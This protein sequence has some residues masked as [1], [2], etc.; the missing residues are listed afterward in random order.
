[1]DDMV[2]LTMSTAEDIAKVGQLLLNRGSYGDLEFFSPGTFEQLL[3]LSLRELY[4]IDTDEARGIGLEWWLRQLHPDAGKNGIPADK[5][6]LSRNVIGHGA[7]SGAVFGIDLDNELVIVQT[8][9]WP[10]KDYEKYLSQFLMAIMDG[11]AK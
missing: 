2:A 3:P 9:D 5:T 1:M 10:A 4:G 11:L 8:R 7:G 6:I